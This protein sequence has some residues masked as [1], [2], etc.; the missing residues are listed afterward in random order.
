MREG[1]TFPLYISC[2][3][4][5]VMRVK[6]LVSDGVLVVPRQRTI[7]DLV[8]LSSKRRSPNLLR[9]LI[10]LVV[11]NLLCFTIKNVY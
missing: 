5:V 3:F 2:R 7:W 11:D 10:D 9:W 8:R 4:F 6:V 1:E